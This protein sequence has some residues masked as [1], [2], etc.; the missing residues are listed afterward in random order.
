MPPCERCVVVAYFID[1]GRIQRIMRRYELKRP[2]VV[3]A[4]ET[5]LAG[6]RDALRGR[7]IRAVADVI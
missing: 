3:A 5:A 1:G 7:G 4:I 2:K 6:M